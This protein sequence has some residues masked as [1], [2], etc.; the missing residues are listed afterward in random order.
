MRH[1]A[2]HMQPLVAALHRMI[3]RDRPRAIVS[4]FPLYAGLL[5]VVRWDMPVP[6]L[7]TVITDSIEVHPA[8]VVAPSDLYCVPDEDT[9]RSM[10][11]HGVSADQVRVTG[12]PVNLRFLRQ[13]DAQ[14]IT[15]SVLYMPST[16]TAHV[17]RTLEGLR[18][19]V[20]RGVRLTIVPGRHSQ[21]LYHLLRRF[22][23]AM[24]DSPI[25]VLSW[26]DDMPRLLQT[27]D[28]LIC[29]AGG[30][31]LHEALAARIPAIIDFVV[32][33]QEEG[34]AELLTKHGCAL[35]SSSPEETC[36]FVDQLLANNAVKCAEMRERMKPLS[37]PEAANRI[38]EL[39]D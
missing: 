37:V 10:Q 21:R 23:D 13:T 24:P 30:A 14:R 20:R 2:D 27:H 9:M 36:V 28:L 19:Q 7:I 5:E 3:E 33:G 4:T 22:T 6:P 17:T 16:N 32:P 12:F 38:A 26:T 1:T 39:L 18:A 34:N 31:I 35:R 29:K 11:V 8:W 25:E 15:P